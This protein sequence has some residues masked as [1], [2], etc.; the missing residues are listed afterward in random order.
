MSI[1][2]FY[3]GDTKKYKVIIR[4]NDTKE[5]VSVDGGTLT[6]TMKKKEKYTDAEA[7]LQEIVTASEVDP[8]D[9]TGVI[10]I[11]LAKEK[12]ALL[13]PGL[14]FYDFQY[15]S[16]IGEVTTI[17]AGTVTVLYDTTQTTTVP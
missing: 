15:E 16:A 10:Q 1:D 9:P 11:T 17:I 14:Y 2:N 8:L 6:V 3:R 12:T 7:S 5:P 4:D 13:D